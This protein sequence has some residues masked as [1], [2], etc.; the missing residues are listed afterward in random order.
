MNEI[1]K[2]E[3]AHGALEQILA[4]TDKLANLPIEK[5]ERLFVIHKEHEAEQARLAFNRA[6]HAVQTEMEPIRKKGWNTH[7]KSQY[8]LAAD[9]EKMLDPILSKHEFSRSTT[10]EDCPTE[11]HTR[12]VLVLR[13]GAGHV[14]RHPMDAP[15]DNVGT[16][17]KPT[18]TVLH[19]MASSYT[20]CERHLLMKVFGVQTGAD[21]DGNTASGV[22]ESA[23]KITASQAA[24]LDSLLEETNS[25]KQKFMNYMNIKQI[26]DLPASEY[27]RAVQVTESK[28]KN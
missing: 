8:A 23:P 9:V 12:F 7:T 5:L 6:F 21:D 17:G 26:E 2:T 27:R 16:G 1:V 24:D 11:G 28:R 25:D 19:G 14:E 22:G 15:I 10:T 13:H 18:K 4:D 20:Y 3:G